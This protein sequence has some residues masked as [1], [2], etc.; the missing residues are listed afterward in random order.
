V[1]LQLRH[2]CLPSYTPLKTIV[3]RLKAV[4]YTF[5]RYGYSEVFSFLYLAP[6][7]R[8][9]TSGA[10][11]PLHVWALRFGQIGPPCVAISHL[12]V[13]C[14]ELVAST[15]CGSSVERCVAHFDQVS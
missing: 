8:S 12:I 11:R 10:N 6:L 13:L 9:A 4:I 2:R 3:N 5:L 1:Y 15:C 14:E 7:A